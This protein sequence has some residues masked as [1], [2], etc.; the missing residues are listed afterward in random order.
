MSGNITNKF[1]KH[2]QI[3]KSGH[4]G[5]P[6]HHIMKFT[7]AA[8]RE[9]FY[10]AMHKLETSLKIGRAYTS[11]PPAILFVVGKKHMPLL[12]ESAQY[13][14]YNMDLYTRT[15]NPGCRNLVGN[16]M[17]FNRIRNV[18]KAAVLQNPGK[19]T[20]SPVSAMRD[21]HS[22]A[23]CSEEV[24]KFSGMTI[25]F[26]SLPDPDIV[27]YSGNSLSVQYKLMVLT[28]SMNSV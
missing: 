23:R 22:E 27:N 6:R 9:E 19:F 20:A 17:F 5:L 10:C 2:G 12:L 18:R 16:P 26:R 25:R 28:V 15:Q 11:L 14:F 1:P 7:H 24:Q 4:K 13:K 21:I 8:Y 3:R